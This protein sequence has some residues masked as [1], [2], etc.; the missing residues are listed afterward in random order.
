M[1]F[2]EESSEVLFILTLRREFVLFL[3]F[4][5]MLQYL[6]VRFE[7]MAMAMA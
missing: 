3:F 7:Y 2:Y 4:H 1:L 5:L 6:M